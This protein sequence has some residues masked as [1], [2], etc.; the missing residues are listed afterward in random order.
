M[1]YK[2]PTFTRLR[3]P[4]NPLAAIE[5]AKIVVLSVFRDLVPYH[6][7]EKQEDQGTA[8]HPRLELIGRHVPIHGG[9]SDD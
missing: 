7:V 5:L 4:A 3:W 8:A 2:D 6:P 9:A 1:R